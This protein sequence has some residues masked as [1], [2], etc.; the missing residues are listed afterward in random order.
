MARLTRT[1]PATVM[2]AKGPPMREY[3][4]GT[5]IDIGSG[6]AAT[7]RMRLERAGHPVVVAAGEAIYRQGETAET[8]YVLQRGRAKSVLIQPSGEA[9]L[10]RI[11]LPSSFLGLTALSERRMRDA[12]AIALDATELTCLSA[13]ALH[14]EMEQDAEL[15]RRIVGT[16]VD[17][18]SDF[19]H[20]VAGLS[21][22]SVRQRLARALVSLSRGDPAEPQPSTDAR[23]SATPIALTHQDLADLVGARRPTVSTELRALER[24][25]LVARVADGLVVVAPDRLIARAGTD[26]KL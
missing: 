11:H 17:R 6:L 20:R 22:A 18:M 3:A 26:P 19:H 16:L 23:T 13:S 4:V 24:D 1:C 5:E 21:D 10:L 25:G 14:D 12:D 8:V 2:R 15:A 7:T 9:T